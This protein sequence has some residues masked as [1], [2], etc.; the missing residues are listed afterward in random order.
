MP[1]VRPSIHVGIHT[2]STDCRRPWRLF[3]CITVVIAPHNIVL[4]L[5]HSYFIYTLTLGAAIILFNLVDHD[6]FPRSLEVIKTSCTPVLPHDRA[7]DSATVGWISMVH[8][9]L[10]HITPTVS[11]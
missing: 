11:V 5:R 2:V 9:T 8:Y 10:D 1:Y 6:L 7:V 4:I 3:V